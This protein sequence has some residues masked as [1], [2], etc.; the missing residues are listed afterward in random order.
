M[1]FWIRLLQLILSLSLLVVLHEFGHFTMARI[2][3]VRVEKFYMFFNLRRSLVRFKK[4]NGKWNV[5]WFAPNVE[6]SLKM[7]VD[8]EGSAVKDSK[9]RIMYEPLS[10][11]ELATLPAD[12]WRRYPE[13]TEWGIGWLPFGGYCRICGMVDET[14]SAAEL[15]S[16]MKPYEYRAKKTWQRMLIIVGGVLFNLIGAMLIYAAILMKWGV[17][18]VPMQN[19]AYGLQYSEL[20]KQQGFQNGDRIISIDGMIPET[21]ADVAEWLLIDGKQSVL[22]ARGA[23]TVCLT[24]QSDFTQQVLANEATDLFDFRFPFVIDDVSGRSPA[25]MADLQGGD[26]IVGINGVST[27]AF[28]DVQEQLQANAGKTIQLE[29]YRNQER[30]VVDVTLGDDAK[31]GV[32]YRSPE[33]YLKVER[34]KYA[35]FPAI[36]AGIKMG[37][38]TLTG[39]VKQF[40]VVFTKEGAKQLGGFGAIGKMFPERWSWPVFWSMTAFLSIILAFMNILPIPVLDG[41]YLIFLIYEMITGRKPSDKFMERT[42]SVG[43]ALI[44]AL[45]IYANL[46]DILRAFF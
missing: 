45:L 16:E 25:A 43:F 4:I 5:K 6:E 42:T 29:Y 21:T 28:Q 34:K 7:K 27:Q 10:D 17:A 19:A 2:F 46:N 22:V 32:L 18:Y 36:P 11:A 3:G 33:T 1:T 37:W 24:M 39:Y 12:D 31:L 38:K 23:D 30:H 9:G 20:M 26:S 8:D 40:K 13:T 41:G 44:F 35:F 15:Q 14:T